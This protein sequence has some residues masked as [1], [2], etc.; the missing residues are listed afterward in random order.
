MKIKVG[1]SNRHAHL[2]KQV[3]DL[4]GLNPKPGKWL[5]I[6]NNYASD[7]SVTTGGL[8]FRVL[9]PFRKYS[10]IEVLAS[11]CKRLGIKPVYR[12]SGQ[13]DGAPTL[14]VNGLDISAI[15]AMPHVHA[16][17]AWSTGKTAVRI[18]GVKEIVLRDIA[19]WPTDD[20]LEPL[21]HID[22]DEARAYAVTPEMTVE[23]ETFLLA[24]SN[25]R[26]TYASYDPFFSAW[27]MSGSIVS[28]WAF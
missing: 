7:T 19:V 21:L 26:F 25:K 6:G 12:Q 8:K 16:P 17:K 15:V 11:D 13:L 28:P 10:Q 24:S 14:N 5:G 22:V 9:L 4:L 2:T 3:A 23:M 1:V 20:C 27:N 18:E